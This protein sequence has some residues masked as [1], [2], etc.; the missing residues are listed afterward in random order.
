MPYAPFL[1]NGLVA[2]KQPH[3]LLCAYGQAPPFDGDTLGDRIGVSLVFTTPAPNTLPSTYE[4]LNPWNKRLA[5][6]LTCWSVSSASPAFSPA[7]YSAATGMLAPWG[8]WT[9]QLHSWLNPQIPDRSMAHCECVFSKYLLNQSMQKEFLQSHP[10]S[11]PVSSP[12][13]YL[14]F[15]F[16]WRIFQPENNLRAKPGS[17]FLYHLNGT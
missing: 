11:D 4:M 9:W 16:A 2:T 3:C 6:W 5:H 8:Q 15:H 12:T 1:L 17:F 13:S 10:G 14:G 7:P